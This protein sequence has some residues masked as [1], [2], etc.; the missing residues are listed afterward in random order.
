MYGSLQGRYRED[1]MSHN[2]SD[3]LLLKPMLP[4]DI[5]QSREG[6]AKRDGA[7]PHTAKSKYYTAPTTVPVSKTAT[8]K[9]TLNTG[10]DLQKSTD[11]KDSSNDVT[12]KVSKPA[13]EVVFCSSLK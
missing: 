6:W 2:L 10:K 8:S 3:H 13:T 1:I 7:K 4:K 5:T 11:E 9:S 12:R